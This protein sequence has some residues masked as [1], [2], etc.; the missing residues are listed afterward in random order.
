[1]LFF[2]AYLAANTLIIKLHEILLALLLLF[3]LMGEETKVD[4]R[5]G[6]CP[7]W[8]SLP[9]SRG[10]DSKPSWLTPKI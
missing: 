5:N 9:N 2:L 10:I 4:R 7:K 6:A 1:M 8:K 3:H